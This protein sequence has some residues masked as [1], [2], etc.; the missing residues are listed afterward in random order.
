M[1]NFLFDADGKT[2]KPQ[3]A[4]QQKPQLN[5][6]QW[7]HATRITENTNMIVLHTS[8]KRTTSIYF[9]EHRVYELHDQ[10]VFLVLQN[11][12]P[13]NKE[14]AFLKLLTSCVFTPC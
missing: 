13:T 10:P 3:L 11:N 12:T 9:K 1:P 6:I 7:W 8:F 14:F 5:K 2:H 4:D